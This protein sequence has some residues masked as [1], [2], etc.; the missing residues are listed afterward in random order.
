MGS[1]VLAYWD[2]KILVTMAVPLVATNASFVMT[3]GLFVTKDVYLAVTAALYLSKAI[4]LT[5]RVMSFVTSFT[6]LVY[7]A[8]NGGL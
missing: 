2:N 3:I 4:V 6:V 5:S 1:F 7:V 8:I